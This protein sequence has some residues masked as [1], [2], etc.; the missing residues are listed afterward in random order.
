MPRLPILPWFLPFVLAACGGSSGASSLAPSDDAGA[1]VA[2]DAPAGDALDDAPEAP[3]APSAPLD[4]RFD[5]G[6]VRRVFPRPDG[7]FVVLIEPPMGLR[8]DVGLPRREVRWID[9]R[10]A[11]TRPRVAPVSVE[12]LLD[13]VVH[14]SGEVSVLYAS[15]AGYRLARRGV[16]GHEIASTTVVDPDVATDPPAAAPGAPVGPIEL[17]SHDGARIAADGEDVVLAGRTARHSVIAYRLRLIDG[18]LRV[19][20]RTLAFPPASISP[21]GLHGG[22][23]DTFGQ[24]DAQYAVHVAVDAEGRAYVGVRYPELVHLRYAKLVRDAFGETWSGDPDGLDSYVARVS[25]DGA[26]LGTTVVSTELPDEISALRADASGAWVLGRNELW[27]D[28]GTGHDALVAR[29]DGASGAASVRAFDVAQ[30]DIAFDLAPAPDGGVLVVGASG[31]VQNPSGASIS[32]ASY[33]FA[34]W[35]RADGSTR[36]LPVPQGPRHNEAR[37]IGVHGGALLIAGMHDGPGTHSADADPTL[38]FARGFLSSVA[39]PP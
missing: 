3:D 18:A 36:D 31:Y 14:A 29:V 17:N 5:G 24:V 21:I 37:W 32:E 10:G 11:E 39:L 38:L 20:T 25:R 9:P 23:Y 30:G 16:D 8:T 26:R 28:A 13:A 33:A 4:L 1:E 15:D 2:A 22:S 35:L 34:R 6:F 27:N 19:A 12:Q 7:G